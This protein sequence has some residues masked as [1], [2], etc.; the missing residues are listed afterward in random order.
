MLP[1]DR[2]L[3]LV[4]PAPATSLGN[5]RQIG[6]R[7]EAVLLE[8]PDGEPAVVERVDVVGEDAYAYLRLGGGEPVAARVRA[9]S[10]PAVGERVSVTVRWSDVH[11]FDGASGQRVLAP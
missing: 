10:R 9:A 6:F 11:V 8:E 5:G 1:A 3:R 7:P 2:P 4:G